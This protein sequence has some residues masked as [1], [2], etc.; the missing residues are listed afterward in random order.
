[1]DKVVELTNAQILKGQS[2]VLEDMKAMNQVGFY[3]SL[4]G[5]VW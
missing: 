3:S 5:I 4:V 1:M 2:E